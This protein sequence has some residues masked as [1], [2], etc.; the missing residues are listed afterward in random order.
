M[1]IVASWPVRS[2]D[3]PYP[4]D[5]AVFVVEVAMAVL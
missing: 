4:S 5:Q 3:P 2:S 1:G